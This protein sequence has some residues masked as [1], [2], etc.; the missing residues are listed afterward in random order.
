MPVQPSRWLWNLDQLVERSTTTSPG[1]HVIDTAAKKIATIV[2]PLP[3]RE[4]AEVG[5]LCTAVTG[6][7]PV[8][9]ARL[10]SLAG[11]LPGGTLLSASAR[12]V[13]TP[14]AGTWHWTRL[15][16]PHAPGDPLVAVVV[17]WSGGP[18]GTANSATL[19]LRGGG[20]FA[21]ANICPLSHNGTTWTTH[22]GNVPVLALRYHDGK[23]H[24]GLPALRAV[25]SVVVGSTTN[26]GEV[27]NRHQIVAGLTVDALGAMLRL[28]AGSSAQLLLYRADGAT[29]A[30][31][32]ALVAGRDLVST[33]LPGLTVLPIPETRPAALEP[34][35]LAVRGLTVTGVQVLKLSFADAATR[36]AAVG[37][38]WWVQRTGTGAWQEDQTAVAAI[39]PRISSFD[40]AGG[41]RRHPG[42][43][44]GL[45]G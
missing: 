34:W 6:V 37:A 38:I 17:G 8:L 31:P 29:L 5:L 33:S 19:S 14:Q 23:L 26:P 24:P 43:T 20:A 35:V 2:R 22:T 45:Q 16:S 18:V 30:A 11:A 10:E 4:I 28:P 13:F 25:T 36:E 41:W 27:G 39:L 1:T 32:P 44:G 15:E 12:G 9:E 21:P 40:T 7:P 3:G 42:L